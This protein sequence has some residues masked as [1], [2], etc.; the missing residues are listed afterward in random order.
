LTANNYLATHDIQCLLQNPDVHFLPV[1]SYLK[2]DESSPYCH[3]SFTQYYP[4]TYTRVSEVVSSFQ[5]LSL[6]FCTYLSSVLCKLRKPPN[7]S[8]LISSTQYLKNREHETPNY[9][10]FSNLLLLPTAQVQILSSTPCSQMSPTIIFILDEKPNAI[11][12]PQTQYGC[13]VTRKSLCS[14]QGLNPSHPVHSQ[15]LY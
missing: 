11:P 4:P 3:K 6:K 9:A 1:G 8:S 2:P 14:C 12:V 7:S 15:T 10:I 5:V 13:P